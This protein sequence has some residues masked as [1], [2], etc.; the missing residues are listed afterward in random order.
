MGLTVRRFRV[1]AGRQAVR[2]RRGLVAL[3]SSGTFLV[4][5]LLPFLLLAAR[6]R[7]LPDYLKGFDLRAWA[8]DILTL[9][10][11]LAERLSYLADQPLLEAG[12]RDVTGATTFY[13]T[14]V[15]HNVLTFAVLAVLTG[16]YA[17]VLRAHVDRRRASPSAGGRAATYAG[18]GAVTVTAASG[19]TLSA[20]ACCGGPV[21]P[22]ILSLLGFGAG[23]GEALAARY[24]TVTELAG[25]AAM[26]ASILYLAQRLRAAPANADPPVTREG[27]P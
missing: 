13:Y 14:L 8:N 17:A 26:L 23:L 1:A 7:A 12:V 2:D 4:F 15:V 10:M 5:L 27:R 3:V 9:P 11:P 21:A 18:A 19:A 6:A 22:A 24:Q 25:L 16:L 20:V